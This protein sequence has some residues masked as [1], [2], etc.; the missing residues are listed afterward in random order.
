MR[1]DFFYV[2]ENNIHNDVFLVSTENIADD[3][4][5][6]RENVGGNLFLYIDGL[7]IGQNQGV[8]PGLTF[9]SKGTFVIGQL[10]KMIDRQLSPLQTEASARGKIGEREMQGVREDWGE[11]NIRRAGRLGRG[12]YKAR[13]KIGEK[14]I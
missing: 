12:K 10:R 13:G 2:T 9:Y 8:H 4:K 14:E 7:L 3:A 1:N 5:R 11:G 6:A